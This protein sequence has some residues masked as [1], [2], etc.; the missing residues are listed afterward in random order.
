[1]TDST[2]IWTAFWFNPVFI[3]FPRDSY[4]K[5]SS[6]HLYFLSEIEG[7]GGREWERE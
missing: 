4:L 5:P 2:F 1:M 6:I 3:F 7:E